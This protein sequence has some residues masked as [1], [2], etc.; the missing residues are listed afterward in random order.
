MRVAAATLVSIIAGSLLAG[1]VVPATPE[2]EEPRAATAADL[3]NGLEM[4][5]AQGWAAIRVTLDT[6]FWEAI[7]GRHEVRQL[8]IAIRHGGYYLAG[9]REPES[10]AMAVFG[11]SAP[12]F[13]LAWDE[14]LAERPNFEIVIVAAGGAPGNIVMGVPG[15][16]EATAKVLP[17][18]QG[19][20]GGGGFVG[21]FPF[22]DTTVLVARDGDLR[23]NESYLEATG[24]PIGTFSP[25]RVTTV[26]AD[27]RLDGPGLAACSLYAWETIG[28]VSWD[29]RF[30]AGPSTWHA[31]G[32]GAWP[33][34]EL[35][36]AAP[37]YF[38]APVEAGPIH[39]DTN[40][41]YSGFI[42]AFGGGDVFAASCA[43]ADLDPKLLGWDLQA[44]TPQDDVRDRALRT[45]PVRP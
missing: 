15:N 31:Q 43:W 18:F 1:C 17:T 40:R 21:R 32:A 38:W 36:D 30:A 45:L 41:T 39:L 4:D 33:G 11:H 7:E 10:G 42:T 6:A 20:S 37:G 5:A 23:F 14:S 9:V 13:H 2:A 22:D 34:A 12:A 27:G 24:T 25:Q 28:A 16:A 3:A 44:H 8:P 26:N 35:A 29:F 19:A